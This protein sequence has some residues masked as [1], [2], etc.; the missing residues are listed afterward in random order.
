[1][2]PSGRA[3]LRRIL[4]AAVVAVL[5]A[6]IAG[7]YA[8]DR[9][10]VSDAILH[11]VGVLPFDFPFLDTDTFMSAVRCLKEGVDVLDANPCDPLRRV[12]D[13][14]PLWLLLAK[15]PVTAAW[16]TPVGI[17]VDLMFIASLLLLPVG[18]TT[19]ATG[20]IVLGVMGSSVLFALERG[21]ND[22]VLFALVAVAAALSCRT[23]ALRVAGYAAAL[24]AGLLKYYPMT[25]MALATRERPIR[26]F[27][28][29]A[30]SA[31]VVALFLVTMGDD[32][33]RA[34]HLIP[35]GSLYGDMFGWSSFAGGFARQMDWPDDAGTPIQV[36]LTL[37]AFG[38]GVVLGLR[39][40]TGRA[41]DRLTDPERMA[42]LAGSLLIVSCFFTA[43]NIG[44]RAIHL[45]LTLPALT[46]L[47]QVRAGRLWT[48][49]MGLVLALLW[50]QAWRYWIPLQAR[51]GTI[52]GWAIREALWWSTIPI[53]IAI[54]TSL[55]VRSEMGRWVTTR[56]R[57]TP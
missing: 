19:A 46:A 17:V 9:R 48:V 34:L 10:D 22:L 15:L 56:G 1:M 27:A 44:Y 6:S 40:S 51:P 50:T 54:V 35:V 13:Y 25:V 53:L 18:R 33:K 5:F 47:W 31:A 14:S 43:Q 23:P 38:I 11:S 41:L 8:T 39:P 30:G 20:F 57:R 16:T 26:F 55:L 49:T 12:F 7:L 32:L 2:E 21:N 37:A 36:G 28:I 42:L 3:T 24:L 29:A 45:A 52:T 4:P